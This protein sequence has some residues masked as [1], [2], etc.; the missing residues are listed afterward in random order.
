VHL[1]TL[2]LSLEPVNSASVM[3]GFHCM[4]K[5]HVCVN[6]LGVW[7]CVRMWSCDEI[8]RLEICPNLLC[9]LLKIG[10]LSVL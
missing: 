1:N 10:H 4:Y 8:Q 7:I 6:V 3:A 2:D 9:N 5:C